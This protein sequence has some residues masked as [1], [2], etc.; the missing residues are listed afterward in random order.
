MYWKSPDKSKVIP[1]QP[2]LLKTLTT[3][4]I[5][6]TTGDCISYLLKDN[7][8]INIESLKSLLLNCNIYTR[9]TPSIKGEIVHY[10]KKSGKIVL[11]C[12]DG[13][14][15]LSAI[16][17][18]HIGISIL[19]TEYEA[20]DSRDL[21]NNIINTNYNEKKKKDSEFV[22]SSLLSSPYTLESNNISLSI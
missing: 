21:E 3:E 10:L 20:D 12:G 19:N 16:K 1:F 7:N 9:T 6:C 13:S 15:D 4:Y 22:T 5:L 8:K 11:M 18:S 14:N 17:Y 2:N